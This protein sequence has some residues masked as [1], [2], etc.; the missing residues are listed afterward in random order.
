MF[1]R[2]K[3]NDRIVGMTIEQVRKVHQAHP[4]KPFTI[5]LGD[6]RS[7]SVRHPEV[8]AILGSGRTILVATGDED[9]EIID[10]L[11][12]TSI[13]SANGRHH[14]PKGVR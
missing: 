10:L 4:F 12:V 8:L 13:G 9:W 2:L 11:L 7:F 5:H 6:G 1:D 3:S 14:R